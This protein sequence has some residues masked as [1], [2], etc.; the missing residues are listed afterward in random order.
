MEQ[1]TSWFIHKGC[2]ADF[3]R[4]SRRQR[5]ANSFGIFRVEQK[6]GESQP[7]WYSN[8]YLNIT[9]YIICQQ[10]VLQQQ[11]KF[12]GRLARAADFSPTRVNSR[13]FPV[14]MLVR[15]CEKSRP[16][17][18][19]AHTHKGNKRKFF[20]RRAQLKRICSLFR[21]ARFRRREKTRKFEA[22]TCTAESYV[23]SV[24]LSTPPRK[25]I[26]LPPSELHAGF[27]SAEGS[28]YIKF[29]NLMRK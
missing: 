11:T 28:L 5:W 9:I 14:R 8:I 17:I 2:C 21:K 26:F 23:V 3:A 1:N 20:L 12:G 15:K 22:S 7:T 24:Q 29:H 4:F 6:R 16:V 25:S 19:H 27:H 13:P 10:T 18:K